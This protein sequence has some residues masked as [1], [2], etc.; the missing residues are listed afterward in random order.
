MSTP[1]P[2]PHGL[3][4]TAA[5]GPAAFRTPFAERTDALATR[6]AW[7]VWAGRFAASAYAPHIDIELNAIRTAAALID[8][9][10]LFSYRVAGPDATRLVDRVVTRDVSAVPPGR[11][12]YTPW[13]D[14]AGKVLDDGTI[15]RLDDGAWRW[16]AAEPQLRWLHLNARGLDVTIEDTR[17]RLGALALQGPLARAVLAAASSADLA[18]LRPFRRRALTIG[19]VACDVSRTGYTGDLG[20]EVWCAAE[21][22]LALWDAL[23]AAGAAYGVRPVGILALDVARIE[24]GLIMLD[25]DYASAAHARV[26]EHAWSP[27]E[28]GLGRFVDLGTGV[29]FVGRAA[30]RRERAAGG[31]PRRLVGL[32]LDGEEIAARAAAH[33]LPAAMAPAAWRDRIP[34][35]RDGS[36]VG[37][38]TS[39]TWSPLLKQALA[40]ATVEAG[41][42]APGTRLRMEWTVDGRRTT[43][44]ATV[45]PLPFYDPP[46]RR[47]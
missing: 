40:L 24:A 26:P 27:D 11:V 35:Y 31:P 39:G 2:T 33:G 18:D 7:R 44:G 47:A 38:A 5:A 22:A 29:P 46:H 21:D 8:I 15:A 23:M 20:Y 34:V 37:V 25:V 4:H 9:S 10:P 36:Q 30:L 12:L 16:T 41:L 6:R 28:L 1:E 45:T 17:D 32:V 42:A 14:E 13:C 3:P 19:D 43:V